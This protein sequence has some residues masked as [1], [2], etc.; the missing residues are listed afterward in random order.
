M[1]TFANNGG[2]IYTKIR[3]FAAVN[4]RLYTKTHKNAQAL[5]ST[6]TFTR[7]HSNIADTSD[8]VFLRQR[9]LTKSKYSKT[10]RSRSRANERGRTAR[11]LQVQCQRFYDV[12]PTSLSA[13]LSRRRTPPA[14]ASNLSRDS[15][16]SAVGYE[17]SPDLSLRRAR[18]VPAPTGC[19]RL[20][21]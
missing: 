12:L 16:V 21:G 9:L 4:K 2:A 1:R 17:T 7:S 3:L 6:Q 15:E 18:T 14:R 20:F 5:S 8:C 10:R 11:R 19:D 13:R